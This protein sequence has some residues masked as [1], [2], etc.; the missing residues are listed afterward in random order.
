MTITASKQ[1]RLVMTIIE[2]KTTPLGWRVFEPPGV[3]LVLPQK[4]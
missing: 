2:I 1:S 4:D 3:E